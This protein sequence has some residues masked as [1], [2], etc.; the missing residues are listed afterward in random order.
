MVYKISRKIQKSRIEIAIE[1]FKFQK[2]VDC[3]IPQTVSATDGIHIE[4]NSPDWESRID[5]FNRRQ[6]YSIHAQAVVGSNLEL[7]DV[8]TDYHG[9]AHDAKILT[10]SCLYLQAQAGNILNDPTE[11]MHG[12][13]VRSVLLGD[14]A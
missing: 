12:F 11:I 7:L 6:R 14:R 10:D 13:Q 3:K 5:Y 8:K 4:I 1:I 2:F 9:S